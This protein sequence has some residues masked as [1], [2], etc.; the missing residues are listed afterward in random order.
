MLYRKLL[1]FSEKWSMKDSLFTKTDCVSR[2]MLNTSTHKGKEMG[3]MSQARLRQH[4]AYLG[5]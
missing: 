4:Q 5:S 3:Q 1:H 2:V